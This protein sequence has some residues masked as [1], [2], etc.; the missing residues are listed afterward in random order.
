MGDWLARLDQI[1][2]LN[3]MPVLTDKGRVSA[4]ISEEH[5]HLHYT[6]FEERRRKAKVKELQSQ[7]DVVTDLNSEIK[8]L[9]RHRK[10]P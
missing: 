8:S 9:G 7:A 4:K 6:A 1:L 2:D 3:E 10:R 5:A